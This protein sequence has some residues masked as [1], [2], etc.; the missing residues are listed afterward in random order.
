MSMTTAPAE[1]AAVQMS[2]E[3]GEEH[4]VTSESDT[5][6]NIHLK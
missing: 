2:A 4:K 6:G 5:E 3:E 1:E